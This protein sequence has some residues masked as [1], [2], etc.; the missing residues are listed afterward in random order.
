MS[1][2]PAKYQ[3]D[4]RQFEDKQWLYDQYWQQGKGLRAI[5]DE[6]DVCMKTIERQ[7]EELGIPRRDSTAHLDDA[8]TDETTGFKSTTTETETTECDWS[9]YDDSA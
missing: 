1:N 3:P 7:M 8:A 4:E 5:G 6:C 9:N 2:V